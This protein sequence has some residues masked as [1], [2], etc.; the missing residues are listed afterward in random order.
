MCVFVGGVILIV[1]FA[2]FQFFIQLWV[3]VIAVCYHGI[4]ETNSAVDSLNFSVVPR[5]SVRLSAFRG[6][7]NN[8]WQH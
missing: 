5:R 7:E 8:S 2:V 6:L 3:A 1:C 4:Q